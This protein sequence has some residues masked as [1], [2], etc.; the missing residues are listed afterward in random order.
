MSNERYFQILVLLPLLSN[1]Y[2]C[3]FYSC[4]LYCQIPLLANSA[5]YI[6]VNFHYSLPL[7]ANSTIVTFTANFHN[8]QIQ[9]QP[10][11]LPK[12]ITC[13]FSDP[14]FSRQS[15]M[16]NQTNK[17]SAVRQM[18]SLHNISYTAF[19]VLIAF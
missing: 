7:L 11:L 4:Y 6:T 12:S 16:H 3:K 10:T 8:L 13:K 18:I 1:S 15:L 5:A 19:F 2:I 14:A 17:N 9:I